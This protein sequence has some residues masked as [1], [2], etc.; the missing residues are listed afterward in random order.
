LQRTGERIALLCNGLRPI[1]KI[2]SLD[3]SAFRSKVA[4]LLGVR[5]AKIRAEKHEKATPPD[6]EEHLN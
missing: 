1:A 5:A 3:N 6:V 2:I 4:S